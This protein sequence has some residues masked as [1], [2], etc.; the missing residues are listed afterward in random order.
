MERQTERKLAYCKEKD[1]R[2]R[3]NHICTCIDKETTKYEYE[4]VK[5]YKKRQRAIQSDRQRG[6]ESE[7]DRQ[8]KQTNK[9]ERDRGTER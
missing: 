7:T 8:N 3:Y 9:N 2:D 1:T 6:I 4:V 5:R